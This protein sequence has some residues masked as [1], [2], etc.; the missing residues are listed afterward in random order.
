[1]SS[2]ASVVVTG[3]S[4]WVETMSSWAGEVRTACT[5]AR[6]RTFLIGGEGRDRLY[7]RAGMSSM[8][9]R[10]EICSSERRE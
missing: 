7:G 4:A 9:N 10:A 6:G 2:A 8:P 1:M 3:S 5:E